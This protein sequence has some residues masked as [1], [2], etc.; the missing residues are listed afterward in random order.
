MYSSLKRY[1]FSLLLNSSVLF[2]FFRAFGSIFHHFGLTQ[3]KDLAAKVLNLTL[4]STNLFSEA[5]T[6]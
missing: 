3:P 1:V 5:L 2:M 6:S 4:G